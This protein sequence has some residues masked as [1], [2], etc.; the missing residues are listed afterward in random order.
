MCFYVK[1]QIPHPW[2]WSTE[3]KPDLVPTRVLVTGGQSVCPLHVYI[4]LDPAQN[5]SYCAQN[6]Q[7]TLAYRCKGKYNGINDNVRRNQN[8]FYCFLGS[9]YVKHLLSPLCPI[10]FS[11]SHGSLDYI[12]TLLCCLLCSKAKLEISAWQ[13]AVIQA[14]GK[15]QDPWKHPSREFS[16]NLDYP[17]S[18]SA[19]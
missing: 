8:R 17:P 6:R 7:Q 3:M 14:T 19:S 10:L 18:T 4:A 11:S 1:I 16:K 5:M 9:H 12:F 13:L 15:T 2:N